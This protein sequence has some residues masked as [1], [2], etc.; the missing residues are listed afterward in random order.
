MS[1]IKQT[2]NPADALFINKYSFDNAISKK[3]TI[4]GLGV[5]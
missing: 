1:K 2:W 4:S 3:S 5:Y